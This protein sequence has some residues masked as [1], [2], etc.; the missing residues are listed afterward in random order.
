MR[1][2]KRSRKNL[3]NPTGTRGTRVIYILI[4]FVEVARI[5]YGHYIIAGEKASVKTITLLQKSKLTTQQ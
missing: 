1:Q 5:A 3:L 4:E 2:S